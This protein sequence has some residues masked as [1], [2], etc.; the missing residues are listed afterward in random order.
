MTRSRTTV[1]VVIGDGAPLLEVAVAPRVFS[2][3][4]SGR[5][6][7]RFDVRVTGE[8]PGRLP[9]TA[10]IAITAPAPLSALNG[11]GLVIVPGWRPPGGTPVR[12]AVLAALRRAHADGATVVGLC[13]GAFVLAEAGLLDGRRATTHWRYLAEFADRHPGVTLVPDALYVDEGSVVTSAGS[14]AGLDA[15]LHLLRREHGPDAANAV[16]RALVV[17]PHRAGGQAQF[18]ERPVPPTPGGDPIAQA[19]RYALEHLDDQRLDVTRLAAAVCLS[20]RSFDRRFRDATG[21]SPLQWL[22]TQRVLR[23]QQVLTSTDLDIDAV[24]RASGF[25]DAVALRPH[26]RRVVGV[27]PRVYRASF[28]PAG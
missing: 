8:H 13:M 9:T 4:L 27:A 20:R 21:C 14:A 23:A 11:A 17:A 24:A 16:A 26:F 25:S 7:P 15:C 19:V 18:V 28:Q 22:L 1:G 10:G 12:P 2:I 3:D 6:G 5:G